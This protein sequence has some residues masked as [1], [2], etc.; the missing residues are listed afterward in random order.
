M[1]IFTDL[2][3]IGMGD[4]SIWP[5]GPLW[6]NGDWLKALDVKELPK[7][8]DEFYD[9]LVRFRDEDPNGNGKKMKFH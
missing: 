5:R 7:S 8:V 1:D 4:T 3:T 6:Y 9:L 2:P